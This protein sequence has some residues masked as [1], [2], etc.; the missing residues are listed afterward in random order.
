MYVDLETWN[1][2]TKCQFVTFNHRQVV[3]LTLCTFIYELADHV[4]IFLLI[5]NTT[6]RKEANSCKLS[7]MKH[8]HKNLAIVCVGS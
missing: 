5:C 3:I 2:L 7:V 4:S 6:V 8:L 1:E